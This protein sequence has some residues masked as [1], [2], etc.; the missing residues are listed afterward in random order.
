MLAV[1]GLVASLAACT[2]DGDA[3]PSVGTADAF[4][5]IVD[6][7]IAQAGPPTTDQPLL[8]IYVTGADGATIDASVQAKVAANTVDVAKVRFTD[9]VDDAL[10]GNTEGEPVKDEGVLLI[11]DEFDGKGTTS[12]P[13]GVTVYRD[14]N[15]EQHLVL[16]VA[17]TTDGAEVTASSARPSG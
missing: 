1:V 15:D 8:V 17:A 7:Q 11:V 3:A 16:T 6:W 4:T 14:A 2:S 10:V 12:L 5:A 9:V 13:I